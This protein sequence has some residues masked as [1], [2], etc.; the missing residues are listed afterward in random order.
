MGESMSP[1]VTVAT[2]TVFPPHPIVATPPS[3]NVPEET[4]PDAPDIPVHLRLVRVLVCG[5]MVVEGPENRDDHCYVCGVDVPSDLAGLLRHNHSDSHTKLE[6]VM[7]GFSHHCGV[8]GGTYPN[9]SS[10][11]HHFWEEKHWRAEKER[12]KTVRV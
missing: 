5:R 7:N 11:W 3:S 12:E 4:H 10:F 6:A 1:V 8:C 9:Y 2:Q